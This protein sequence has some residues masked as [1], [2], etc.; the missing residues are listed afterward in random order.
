VRRQHLP[1]RALGAERTP[2]L[3]PAMTAS[4][5]RVH[6]DASAWSLHMP[7][8]GHRHR[9]SHP[10]VLF[11]LRACRRRLAAADGQQQPHGARDEAAAEPLRRRGHGPG[12][13]QRAVAR[14]GVEPQR[15]DGADGVSRQVRPGVAACVS[16]AT[17]H[18][19]G[20]PQARRGRQQPR[21]SDLHVCMHACM[22]VPS[23]PCTP[24]ERPA[25]ERCVC[26]AAAGL[27]PPGA[28]PATSGGPGRAPGLRPSS[29]C[30]CRGQPAAAARGAGGAVPVP[31]PVH[32]RRLWQ[33]AAALQV[34][35]ACLRGSV[36]L[37]SLPPLPPCMDAA[38]CTLRACVRRRAAF[39]ST[40]ARS[41]DGRG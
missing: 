24:Q 29:R 32:W 14:R 2:Q 10:R 26:T 7:R 8:A 31:G 1:G 19:G 38:I 12:G 25:V 28:Q 41:S 22:C 5:L 13:T 18:G 11:W 40:N 3:P 16:P 37:P 27:Y 39:A 30:C 36:A 23:S 34:R 33:P 17:V 21:G 20:W 9:P 35:A 15:H 4:R 6:W